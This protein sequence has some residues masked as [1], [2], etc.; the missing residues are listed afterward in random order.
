MA[1]EPGSQELRALYR[2]SALG[3][4]I[5]RDALINDLLAVIDD[6]VPSACPLLFVH[7]PELD[8]VRMYA[9]AR[10]GRIVPFA[11]P[12]IVRRVFHARAGEVVNDVLSDADVDL[13]PSR[14][15]DARQV[16]IAPLV[17]GDRCLGAVAAVNSQRGAFTA[18]DLRALTVIADRAAVV[19]EN[20]EL[21]AKLERQAQELEG[22]VRLSRL[23]T[24]SESMATIVA[25]S[26]RIVGDLLGCGKLA[27]LLHD[28]ERDRLT[29]A[30][31]V[32]GDDDR[33]ARLS[34]ELAR[35]GLIATVFR[36]NTPLISNDAAHDAW[37]GA[38]LGDLD[39][40]DNLLAAPLASG[41]Q[42]IGVL[43]AANSARGHFEDADIRFV[44]L[45]SIR[46]AS[47]L[48]AGSARER[49][50]ALVQSLR[51]ADRTKTEFVS[52]LAHELKGPMT[53]IMGFARILQE[54]SVADEAKRDEILGIVARE[55][56]RLSRLVN[57]L[58]DVS[59]MDSGTLRYEMEPV[60]LGD[61]VDNL[62]TVHPSLSAQHL[63]T[64]RVPAGLPKVVADRDRVR[65]V[66]MNLLTNATRY[67]PEGTEVTIGAA[68]VDD[69]RKVEV[70]VSDQGIGIPDED[71]DRIFHKFAML[72]KPG[73]VRKGTGL[74]LFITRAI[75][76]A[77][78]GDIWVE[79]EPA[80][81]STFRFTLRVAGPEPPSHPG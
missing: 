4:R 33:L 60:A 54:G 50:R 38:D 30:P 23:V 43:V 6:V 9:P 48:E 11:T 63:V 17:M 20:A 39:G 36:T 40:V 70:S 78:G 65:Q 56:E 71:R 32:V 81:G 61:I 21:A 31:P 69:G 10:D 75:V 7:E 52:M 13:I 53:T 55:V 59:R 68:V 14:E 77:H 25:E 28:P 2:V 72:P 80:K 66:L 45:L 29:V 73:W 5:E 79:S 3:G 15:I 44:S 8:G 19:L 26:L 12:S 57:D 37:V 16:V 76:E 34:V 27:V 49:E 74:G 42:P 46:V 24:S 64:A 58:L 67:S 62:L 35:P 1:T 41:A 47:V 18:G 22:L 51:E